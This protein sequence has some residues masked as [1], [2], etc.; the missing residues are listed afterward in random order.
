MAARKAVNDTAEVIEDPV[1]FEV[2]VPNAVPDK[3]E[4]EKYQGWRNDGGIDHPVHND[5]YVD[6][7]MVLP[8]SNLRTI[9]RI[10]DIA[11]SDH[12]LVPIDK[13]LGKNYFGDADFDVKH[14]GKITFLT[15]LGR[16]VLSDDNGGD[17]GVELDNHFGPCLTGFA[18]KIGMPVVMTDD[19]AETAGRFTILVSSESDSDG[20][21][22]HYCQP[23]GFNLGDLG[24]L[25]PP[26]DTR[27]AINLFTPATDVDDEP[28]ENGTMARLVSP[29][30]LEVCLPL[31]EYVV[32][33]S[34]K[35]LAR[36]LEWAVEQLK[37]RDLKKS[38]K[39]KAKIDTQKMVLDCLAKSLARGL[40][41]Q[42]A[43]LEQ[44][45]KMSVSN[46]AHFEARIIE[47]IRKREDFGCALR[48]IEAQMAEIKP[49]EA[50]AEIIRK[51]RAV[52][53]VD[54]VGLEGQ[55]LIVVTK[56]LVSD[57]LGDNSQRDLGV[58]KICITMDGLVTLNN[59]TRKV[60]DYIHPHQGYVG[61]R[62]ICWGSAQAHLAK[63]V[64]LRQYHD[65]VELMVNA[66]KAI[67]LN[68]Q[69]G[70]KA[71]D[72]PVHKTPSMRT[73]KKPEAEKPKGVK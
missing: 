2:C 22:C 6:D 7:A 20:A 38:F 63:M 14:K 46:L 67:N 64:G 16:V 72:W 29:T 32:S 48:V 62:S 50:A 71:R 35:V 34:E 28:V 10:A 36:I 8:R 37:D 51:L 4:D 70:Q 49:E 21:N 1:I 54:T 9:L 23:F 18:K 56:H 42:K 58:F 41:E 33:N 15:R 66:L 39:E 19:P 40:T 27:P 5:C 60:H 24:Y 73:R 65:A 57:V 44:N 11:H 3:Y 43:Q 52:P 69:Y 45:L 47:E 25:I 13:Q 30:Y 53:D 17:N 31:L 59:L 12:L 26:R 68:D 61:D 55:S